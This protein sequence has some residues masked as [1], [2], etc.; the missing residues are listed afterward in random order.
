L[1]LADGGLWNNLGSHVLR[2]DGIL[3]GAVGAGRGMPMLCVNSSAAGA[4]SA[5]ATYSIPVVAQFAAL[6]RTLRVLTVNTVQPRVNA[7][8]DAMVRRNA[9][10]TRPGPLDPLEV[11]V[12]LS[13]VRQHEAAVGSLCRE[14]A[15]PGEERRRQVVVSRLESW[16][17]DV[18]GNPSPAD[19]AR[20]SELVLD[21]LRSPTNGPD[22][23]PCVLDLDVVEDL[24]AEPWWTTLRS[25][26][27][28]DDLTLRTTLDRVEREHASELILRGYANTWLSS[29]LIDARDG[30]AAPPPPA[31]DIVDR[32]HRMV[33]LRRRE[34]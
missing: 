28:P 17:A 4:A 33:G 24:V 18:G 21:A 22:D 29:L 11:V 19:N 2:E 13:S 26:S 23:D 9:A 12:D 10:G 3:H 7:I 34:R 31:A 8:T 5:P 16:A 1:F 14:R 20:L 6:F 30:G 32:V 27:G 15:D 25:H